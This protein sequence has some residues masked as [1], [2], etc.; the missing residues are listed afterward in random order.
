MA[1]KTYKP[2]SNGRRNMTG[3]TFSEITTDKPE[4]SLLQPLHKK[5]GRNNQGRTTVRFR[6]GGH[7]R[8]YRVI[9]FKR[10]KDGIPGR[11]ASIE[12]DPNRSANIALI[13]YLDGE[14]RY[15]LAPKNLKVGMEVMSGPDA[16]IKV[17][18]AL[19]LAN[20]PVGTVIHNIELK[21]G[22]GG[23]LV[24]AAGTSAQVLGKEGKYVLVRLNSGEVRMILATCRATVGQVGNEQ[25][26][27][28]NIGKAGRARW[29]GRRPHV[30]GSV[31]NPNDHPHG[32]GEG[33]A[34]IGRVSPV[35]PWGKPTLGYKT[36]KKNKPSDKF[37]VRRRKK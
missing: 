24:R 12:Y 29:L 16:D 10:N 8:Q 26:E 11:V 36:R 19:P 32:G 5:G 37:I 1:I 21:P 27:L 3:F 30:R 6:G 25:H 18:N 33:K 9:D 23:Q 34:P 13:H 31:M 35:T 20:I 14:K 22:K 15:I 17:G 7:K 28:I 2:T 4:K